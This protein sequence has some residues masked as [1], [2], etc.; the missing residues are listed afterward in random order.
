MSNCINQ[1]FS[2]SGVPTFNN[3]GNNNW[4][5]SLPNQQQP[6]LEVKDIDFHAGSGSGCPFHKSAQ[7]KFSENPGDIGEQKNF[8]ENPG[9]IG[10]GSPWD[11][12]QLMQQLR[13]LFPGFFE[14][15]NLQDNGNSIEKLS[16]VSSLNSKSVG[17]D[18]NMGWLS[19][20]QF[21]NF[22]SDNNLN[23]GGLSL[24]QLQNFGSDKNLN[25]GGL[26]LSQLQNFGS[27]KNL[28]MGGVSL[29]QLPDDGSD[30]N[31]NTEKPSSS[32]RKRDDN[33]DDLNTEGAPPSKS[34][35]VNSN[36]SPKPPPPTTNDSTPVSSS[37]PATSVLPPHKG[38]VEVNKPIIVGPGETYDGKNQLFKAGSGLKGNGTA[39]TQDP[40]FIL[41][42]GAKLKNV[43]F[44][45]D[46]GKGNSYGDGIH[47]LGDA[48]LDNVHAVHGGP[49]DMI[50]IDGA[51]NKERDAYLAGIPTSSIP[52]KPANV[53]ITNSSFRH[54][55]D[56]AIQ[57]NGDANVT[58]KGVYAE[59][60]GQL[61]V[62]RGG[63]PITAHVSVQDSTVKGLRSHLIR[64]DSRNSTLDINNVQTD[65]GQRQ[66]MMGDPSKA[67]GA[68]RVMASTDP[69]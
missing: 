25:M 32:K 41:A 61:L 4:G 17:S 63:Y 68:T 24:S 20:P 65:N 40:M 7:S 14:N 69:A 58:L 66:V 47:L 34:Q 3:E 36:D 55:H 46:D 48:K 45:G 28:N 12:S 67:K 6:S 5:P 19:L 27:D 51:G 31:L 37:S 29:S 10:N 56:K 21:Q 15:T 33:N 2:T 52:N 43:Q 38:E 11:M 60:V 50:T 26:S 49:D 1:N 13:T 54:A 39:E 8:S 64:L 57:V 35:K 16:G 44:S 9:D 22:G 23:M 59:D 62:T 30:K 18:L 53:E 42:P